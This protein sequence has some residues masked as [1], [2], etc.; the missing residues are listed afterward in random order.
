[1]VVGEVVVTVVIGLAAG[2]GV[3][4]LA[5]PRIG[6]A[7]FGVRPLDPVTFAVAVAFLLAV[8]WLAAYLPARRAAKA[9]PLTALRAT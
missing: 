5:A 6:D 9:D 1:M 8:S 3:A 7:L 4:A 2:I